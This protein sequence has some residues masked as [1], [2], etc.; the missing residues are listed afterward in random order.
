MLKGKQERIVMLTEGSADVECGN[1]R[2]EHGRDE[3]EGKVT[4]LGS[5]F[6]NSRAQW[7]GRL[8]QGEDIELLI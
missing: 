3:R 2:R 1:G 8:S 5:S 6:G 4:H 7:L